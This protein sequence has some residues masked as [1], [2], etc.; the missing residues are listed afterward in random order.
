MRRFPRGPLAA[1]LSLLLAGPAGAQEAAS[2]PGAGERLLSDSARISLVTIVPGDKV[3]SIFGHNAIRVYDPERGIDIAYNY[4]T[5]DFGNP[6]VFSAKFLYGDLNY[7]LARQSFE[8]MASF[9]PLEEGRP[10]VEQ[11]LDL[12]PQQRE[13]VYR[14]LEWNAAPENAYYRYDFY[15]D[16]CATRIRDLLEDVLG[17]QLEVEAVDPGVS[18]RQLLDPYLVAKPWLH[19]GMDVGQ[20]LPADVPATW[21]S[22]LFLPDRLAV[23][24]EAARVLGPDGERPLVARIDSIGW[25]HALPA[26]EAAPPWPAWLMA[27]FLAA[28][29]VL[30]VL[31]ARGGRSG[32]PWFDVPVFALLG[33][34]GLLIGFLWFV[35]LHAVTRGNVN[36]LWALPTGLAL[37]WGL[38][39]ARRKPWVV[40]LLWITAAGAG[41]FVGGWALWSQEVPV[42]TLPLALAVTIRAGGL[43][44]LG[45]RAAAGS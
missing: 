7:R 17:D 4:G 13:E 40:V 26:R 20:G 22:E 18:M 8:R 15:Y 23:W 21:R 29:V 19:F 35:S 34:A 30:T 31:D 32:R 42:A 36:L 38:R 27:L 24:A 41:A 25:S 12:D 39:G 45:R 3:Y 6:V 5:F 43:A 28:V 1:L 9:Y 33:V 11:R 16:N 37:V 44:V 14:F 10:I 2:S